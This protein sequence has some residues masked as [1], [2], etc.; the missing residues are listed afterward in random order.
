MGTTLVGAGVGSVLRSTA[1]DAV[2]CGTLVKS[3]IP[4]LCV[5]QRM[6]N[7]SVKH[8]P[9]TVSPAR[10]KGTTT[11]LRPG[12]GD[13]SPKTDKGGGFDRQ[14]SLKRKGGRGSAAHPQGKHQ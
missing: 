12:G 10:C 7:L 3:L 5:E 14:N 1:K 11:N 4:C 9:L 2:W 13:A 6:H 8:N